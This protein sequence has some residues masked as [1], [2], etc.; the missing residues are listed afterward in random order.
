MRR[1]HLLGTFALVAAPSRASAQPPATTERLAMYC[2]LDRSLGPSREL[3]VDLRL[4]TGRTGRPPN[5]AD[6]AAVRRAGGRPLYAFHVAVL[7]AA[8]DTTALRALLASRGGIAD[9]AYT[10]P[11][12][13]R[14]DVWLQLEFAQPPAVLDTTALARLGGTNIGW[15]PDRRF[16]SLLL[17]DSL[18]PRLATTVGPAIVRAQPMFCATVGPARAP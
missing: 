15:M 4:R 13:S 14:R 9:V 16:V 8:V 3:V 10:V 2:A 12:T 17:P 11:D 5:G 1:L 18:V 7:R 6:S